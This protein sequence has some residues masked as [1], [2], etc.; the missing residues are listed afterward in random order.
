MNKKVC[1]TGR[2]TINGRGLEN[3]KAIKCLNIAIEP[4]KDI[5]LILAPTEKKN[6][7]M[8]NILDNC[9]LKT[10]EAGICFSLPVDYVVGLNK[11][12]NN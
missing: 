1:A 9:G 12:I 4:E 3:E 2:T 8:K 5:I 10:K 7:I 11:E 6:A